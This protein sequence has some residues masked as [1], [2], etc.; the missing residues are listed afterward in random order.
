MTIIQWL[1]ETIGEVREWFR[2][3]RREFVPV[4]QER[5]IDVRR[6]KAFYV[7]LIAMCHDRLLAF[8]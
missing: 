8:R 2:P 4:Y 6:R 5:R 7:A 3:I 1:S